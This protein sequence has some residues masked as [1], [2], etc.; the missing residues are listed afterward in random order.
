VVGGQ[1]SVPVSV[2]GMSAAAAFGAVAGV[3]AG[4]SGN[5]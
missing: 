2:A 4:S 5:S 3:L 1:L